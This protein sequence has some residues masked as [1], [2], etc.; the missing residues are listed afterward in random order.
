[1]DRYDADRDANKQLGTALVGT[2]RVFSTWAFLAAAQR[3]TATLS[4]EYD[5]ARNPLGL[6]DNGL[7]AT[8]GDDRFV[9]RAQAEF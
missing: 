6:A 3:G 2:H 4:F 9:V 8:I 7:P 1:Y 5:H